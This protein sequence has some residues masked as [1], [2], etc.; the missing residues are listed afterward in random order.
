M[1]RDENLA[2]GRI[3]EDDLNEW[4]K[5]NNLAYLYVSQAAGTFAPL[6]LENV[7]RPD[8]LV[9]LES[10][11]LIAVDAK[12]YTLSVG[13]EYTLKLEE[14][15]Q[16][17]MTFERIF[18]LP[19]WYAYRAEEEGRIVWYWISALKVVEVGRV[20]TNRETQEQ[21][22]AIKREYF[23]RIERNADL[24]KLYT[25]RLPGYGRIKDVC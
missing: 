8:F 2:K 3:G 11:G 14:E 15:V 4:L 22:L 12:N 7:K 21:F 16:R 6:F 24:G 5:A 20:R 10:I 23:E 17:V 9:L 18:R 13:G 19:F 1:G 25:H